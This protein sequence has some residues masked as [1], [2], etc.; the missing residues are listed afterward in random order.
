VGLPR[1]IADTVLAS[2]SRGTLPAHPAR[3]G[4]RQSPRL[5]PRQRRPLEPA[6]GCRFL[7]LIRP[8]GLD[9]PRQRAARRR[10]SLLR[11]LMEP[12][13]GGTVPGSS[14]L[15][16]RQRRIRGRAPHRPGLPFTAGCVLHCHN[17]ATDLAARTRRQLLAHRNPQP[18]RP[19]TPGRTTKTTKEHPKVGSA[20]ESHPVL[21]TRRKH[22]STRSH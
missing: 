19:P 20:A 10:H 22:P 4:R 21:V 7:E 2:P 12:G 8:Q 11:P 5:P 18:S 16:E 13:T 9:R 15:V 17:G 6:P 1:Y 3:A 14:R